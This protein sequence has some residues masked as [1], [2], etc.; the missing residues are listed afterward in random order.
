MFLK[1]FFT[2]IF[3]TLLA[4]FLFAFSASA[5][6]T[7]YV[8]TYGTDTN[9]GT[10]YRPFKTIKKGVDTIR[11]GDTLYVRRG[12]YHEQVRI[13]SSGTPSSPIIISGYP[14]ERPIIDGR[15]ILP[16]GPSDWCD[17]VSGNCLTW[18]PLIK[19]SSN[20]VTF[21]NFEVKQSR[22]RGVQ[23]N[24][25]HNTV[26]NCFMQNSRAG[27]IKSYGSNNLIEGN[28]VWLA[29]NYAQYPRSASTLNWPGGISTQHAH[30]ITIRGNEVF[31]IWGE[32]II[33]MNS[34][35][36]IIEDNIVYDNFAVGIYLAT[37]EGVLIQRNLVYNTNSEPFLRG[38]NPSTGITFATEV[39][40]TGAWSSNQVVINNIVAG[41]RQNI[42]WW[43][44]GRSGALINTLIANNTLINAVSNSG[45]ATNI[46]I[47]GTE[48]HE[49]VQIRNNI[50]VQNTPGTIARVPDDPAF[51]F[52]NNLWSKTPESDAQGSGD[53]IA[54][55]NL[56][57]ANG[58][59][60][61]GHVDPDW[62]R[63]ANYNSP[64]I[65]KALRLTQVKKDYFGLVRDNSPDI[66]A[67]E[68]LGGF[69]KNPAST[70][71]PSYNG[72]ANNTGKDYGLDFFDWFIHLIMR[73]LPQITPR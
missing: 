36:I 39:S 72:E 30:D 71:Q 18:S 66:G 48:K 69:P 44:E 9:P 60:I 31:H 3:V 65:G 13:N 1:G 22:G 4:F 17:P 26:K 54:N 24:G 6:S 32:G 8:A 33:P 45:D 64:A 21:R 27:G 68:Y 7:Y 41:H 51:I 42:A 38:G 67:D 46:M 14:G 16:T 47:D 20:Y 25:S 5:T 12:I 55:P 58:I 61:A 29:A 23:I 43:G 49:N 62:Y 59:L 11:A 52:S 34:R 10:I 28:K 70:I 2:L 50:I 57:N 73:N 19:I 63:L 15:Y 35:D 56:V 37:V 53:I 40:D